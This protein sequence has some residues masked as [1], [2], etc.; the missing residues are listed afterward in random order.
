MRFSATSA[1]LAQRLLSLGRYEGP[2]NDTLARSRDFWRG[3]VD[4]NGSLG[5]LATGYAYCGLCGSRRLLEAFLGFLQSHDLGGRMTLRPDKSV[6]QVGTAGYLA[7]RIIRL[8]Y[9]DAPVALDRKAA[10][11]ARI[12]AAEDVRVAAQLT[13]DR[14]ELAQIAD[15]Y[16]DGAS[17]MQIGLRLGISNVT[18][19]KRME[20]AGMPRRP[21]VGGRRGMAP[22]A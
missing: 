11:A 15:L 3:A 17:L 4:G 9:E 5:I 13:A 19:M 10:S 14:V 2:V 21:R 7:E 1:S 8:L 16:Q 18:V 20:A 12:A 22:S 6:F